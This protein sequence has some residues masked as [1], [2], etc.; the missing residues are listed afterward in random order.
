MNDGISKQ[1][2]EDQY[3]PNDSGKI[4]DTC[5]GRKNAKVLL[6]RIIN[7]KQH[8]VNDLKTI[9]AMLPTSLTPLQDEALWNHLSKLQQ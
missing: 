9:Q 6:Q 1:C 8:E 5:C 4:S 7:Q 3:S 2:V